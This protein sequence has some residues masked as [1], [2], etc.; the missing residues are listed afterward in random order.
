MDETRYKVSSPNEAVHQRV[1]R[2]VADRLVL[3]NP[4]RLSL[5]IK[6]PSP[7]L[8]RRVE[9]EGATISREYQYEIDT[10]ENSAG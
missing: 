9:Q 10:P 8:V 4:R 6:D 2:I 1:R 5:S 3:E 7:D